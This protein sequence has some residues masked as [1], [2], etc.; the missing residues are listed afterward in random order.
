[1]STPSPWTATPWSSVVGGAITAQPEGG[2]VD[3]D[4]DWGAVK[5]AIDKAEGR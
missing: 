1:M 3:A 2:D 4:T 5:A